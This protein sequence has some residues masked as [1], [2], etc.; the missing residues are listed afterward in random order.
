[1]QSV[2]SDTHFG[3]YN[4]LSAVEANI[5]VRLHFFS[6]SIALTSMMDGISQFD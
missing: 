1:M 3:A 5:P 4:S 2:V 6:P